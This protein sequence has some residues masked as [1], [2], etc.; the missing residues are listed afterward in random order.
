[1][2]LEAAMSAPGVSQSNSSPDTV[3]AHPLDTRDF[4]QKSV[5]GGLAT[6]FGQVFGMVLQIGTMLILARLLSPSDYGLQSMVVTVTAFFSLFKDAGLSVATVQ[7]DHLTEE[8]ISTLF[9]LN[10]A[11]GLLLTLLVAAMAPLLVAIYREPRLLWLTVASSSAF[12]FNS[13]AVQH[14]ALME[15]SMRFVAGVKIDILCAVVGTVIAI[16]MAACGFGYW[17]L[18]CQNISLPI[19]GTIAVWTSMPWIPGRPRWSRE[20]R[21]MVR[22]GTTVTLNSIIVYIAYNSEKL[23]LGRYWGASSLGIYG[24]AYQLATLPVQQLINAVHPVAFSAL[25]RM[26]HEPERLIQLFLKSLSLIV[27]LIVPI[28]ISTAL[29][30]EDI[31]RVVLGV[32]WLS[33]TPVLRLLSP[34]V[35]VLMLLNPFS[36]FLRATGRVGRSLNTAFLICPMVIIGIL[37]GLPKGP[38]GVAIGYSTAMALVLGPVVVWAIHGT[39]ITLKAYW[40]AVQKPLAAGALAGAAGWFLHSACQDLLGAVSLLTVE[41]LV[42]SVIYGL[43]LVFAMGQKTLYLDLVHQLVKGRRPTRTE[44]YAVSS[45]ESKEC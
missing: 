26:Q 27:S 29:F 21:P 11:I 42:V 23:L 34:T 7:R 4:K 6:I 40:N 22:F 9:W 28:V 44:D 30:P 18:I 3:P 1:M 33:V 35:L 24:R 25:S 43:I 14:R 10:I 17:A 13:L 32:K 45:P 2:P 5:R 16:G 20:L 36:W 15:R 38:Q 19:V 8:Q 41:L 31:V 39:G 37:I 12:L